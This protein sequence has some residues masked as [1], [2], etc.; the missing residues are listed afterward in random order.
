[1]PQAGGTVQPLNPFFLDVSN[2]GVAA[3]G[4]GR[5]PLSA[6]YLRRYQQVTPTTANQGA[7]CLYLIIT[8]A[9][10]DGEARSQ[11]GEDSIGD[12]DGDGA[13]EFLDGWGHPIEFLRSA[14]GFDSQVQINANSFGS[15][16]PK[17]NAAWKAA[18]ASDHDPFDLYRVDQLPDGSGTAAFRLVPL[19]YSPGRDETL[20]IRS[21]PRYVAHLG[22]NKRELEDAPQ[23]DEWRIILPWAPINDPDVKTSDNPVFLG[24]VL[25]EG[26]AADNIHNHLLGRR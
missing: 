1:V 4:V 2:T 3:T 13:Y 14:P 10:G 21:A 17:D 15:T 8:L 25:P 5:T 20:G 12:T 18:A 16:S 9:C 6:I 19:I 26:G 24:T 7:E 23:P 11:F 22:L